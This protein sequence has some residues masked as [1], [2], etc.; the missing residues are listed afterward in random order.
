MTASFLLIT[1]LVR[2]GAKIEWEHILIFLIT[3]MFIKSKG[4]ANVRYHFIHAVTWLSQ[5]RSRNLR[6]IKYNFLEKASVKASN[7]IPANKLKDRVLLGEGTFGQI[8]KAQ[9]EKK[10]GDDEDKFETVA[11]KIYKKATKAEVLTEG[12]YLMTLEDPNI[13]RLIGL[14]LRCDNHWLVMEYLPDG[15]LRS[16]I[17]RVGGIC[18]NGMMKIAWG[19]ARGMSYLHDRNIVHGDLAARNCLVMGRDYEVKVGDFGC[20]YSSNKYCYYDYDVDGSCPV[21]W[22]SPENLPY[23]FSRYGNFFRKKPSKS[24][25]GDVWSFGIVLFELWSRGQNPFDELSNY[26]ACKAILEGK[27][28]NHYYS[29]NMR[30]RI[31]DIMHSC[32]QFQQ[33]YRPSFETIIRHFYKIAG[34]RAPGDDSEYITGNGNVKGRRSR[35]TQFPDIPYFGGKC[36]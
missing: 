1:N 18:G 34:F 29:I 28:P 31:W 3:M 8:F 17:I 10:D 27:K 7:V 33:S 5:W 30:R 36:Y 19:I 32:W 13:V 11:V 14:V 9:W 23:E 15:D 20:Y 21:R 25:D 16:Y 24:I 26:R 22:M 12:R 2:N 6:K 4:C 35:Y